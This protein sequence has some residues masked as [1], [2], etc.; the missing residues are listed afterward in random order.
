MYALSSDSFLID[1]PAHH[2]F[3]IQ[4]YRLIREQLLAEG[5]LAPEEVLE[6]ALVDLGDIRLVHTAAYWEN[7]AAGSLPASAI[8]RLGLPWSE[9]LI[10]RSRASAQGTLT[11]ARI[12]I[13]DRVAI[14][15]AGGTHHAFPDRGE[16]YCVLND[17]AIAIRC[18][19]RDA[20]MQR[21]AIIDCDVHQGNG[22]AAIFA[23]EPD[24]HTFSIHGAN[25]YPLVKVPGSLDIALPDET[26]DEEYL[27]A[28]KEAVPRILGQFRP[29]LVFYL[30]GVDPHERD[31]LGR[32][33]L[34]HL[35]LRQ[36]DEF[37]LQM[38]RDA[39]I[40]VAITLGGGYG[41][42]LRETVEA[43]CNTVRAAKAVFDDRSS[44]LT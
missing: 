34:T 20:W 15:L 30:A 40:P 41:Q 39:D 3:P 24:V 22:S 1:L 4:K 36:R 8:R 18:L 21:M 23:H 33:R 7:L 9:A 11:A 32:L 13:R 6:P 43:H 16:G 44:G 25:N 5:T 42:L 12:A 19:Q 28:L 26:R 2:T 38:C 37:V 27:R 29:G 35:G 31:R 10:R 14:N 17:I